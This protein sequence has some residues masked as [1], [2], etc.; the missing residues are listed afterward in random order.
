MLKF[1]TLSVLKYSLVFGLATFGYM[2]I[3]SASKLIN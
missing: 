1:I 3:S 2:L